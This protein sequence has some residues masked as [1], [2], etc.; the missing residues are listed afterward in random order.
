MNV[1]GDIELKQLYIK[2]QTYRYYYCDTD[3]GAD[4]HYFNLDPPPTLAKI[5]V[6]WL[7]CT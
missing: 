4:H 5:T 2:N 6:K 3:G 7:K 1:R